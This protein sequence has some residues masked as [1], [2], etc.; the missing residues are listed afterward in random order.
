MKSKILASPPG[1]GLLHACPSCKKSFALERIS[2][3]KRGDVNVDKY[4][5]KHCKHEVEHGDRHPS[6]AV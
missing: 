5:C 2:R 6:G 1:V 3:E 4:R